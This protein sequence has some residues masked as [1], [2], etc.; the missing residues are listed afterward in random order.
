MKHL[1]LLLLVLGPLPILICSWSVSR[2]VRPSNT[3]VAASNTLVFDLVPR[4]NDQAGFVGELAEARISDEALEVA[5][6]VRGEQIDARLGNTCQHIVRSPFII[7]G[8][9]PTQ[10]LAR[11]YERTILPA[12]KAL[13]TNYFQ[14]HPDEPIVVLLFTTAE[15]YNHF[16][17]S[18]FGDEGI[19]IFGYYKPRQRTLVMNISTGGG[20]LLHEL[21]HALA[22]FDFPEIPD[23]FNEGLASLHEQ[24]RLTDDPPGIEGLINWRLPVIRDAIERQRLGTVENLVARDDFRGT[25]EGV[26]YAQA[27]YFCY[28]MQQ[29]G[30][31]REFYREFR[32]SYSDDPTG[33]QTVRK[34]F[35]GQSWPEIDRA[36]RSWL[37]T[38]ESTTT[39]G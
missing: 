34:T 23:W 35:D 38:L 22:D 20:T 10:E 12:S 3:T 9:L 26:N 28:Y 18:L 1:R 29:Q 30:L 16:A 2:W 24:A 5:C 19:S 36:F 31:L 14:K 15:S 11:W 25:D 13:W 21:T 17:M 27:R 7:A 8:D 4:S 33:A 37:N 39:A 6:H 32:D